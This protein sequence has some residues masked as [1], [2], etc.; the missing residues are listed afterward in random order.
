VAHAEEAKLNEI[1]IG[2]RHACLE[3]AYAEEAKLNEI[4]C[5][6]ERGGLCRRDQAE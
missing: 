2:R 6:F 5:R 4:P 1:T 3:V